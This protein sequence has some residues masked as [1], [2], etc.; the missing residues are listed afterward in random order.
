[1]NEEKRKKYDA[2]WMDYAI[3]AAHMSYARRRKVGAVV[4]RN[5]HV[6]ATGWNGMPEGED[7]NCEDEKVETMTVNVQPKDKPNLHIVNPGETFEEAVERV[8]VIT[9]QEYQHDIDDLLNEGWKILDF[10]TGLL[11]RR[12]LVTKPDVMHAELNCI[13][14]LARSTESATGGTLYITLSP[15]EHCVNIIRASGVKRVVWMDDYRDMT[16]VEKLKANKQG[17]VV[18]KFDGHEYLIFNQKE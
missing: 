6:L 7:N 13:L 5:G 1:M 17:I 4:V 12:S 10:E 3:R 16:G 2:L 8:G 15:C 11:E 14:K 9:F 18:E